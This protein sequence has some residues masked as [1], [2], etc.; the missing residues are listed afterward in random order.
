MTSFLVYTKS[1]FSNNIHQF[2]LGFMG[3]FCFPFF[4]PLRL[5]RSVVV[6]V[7][8]TTMSSP[9]MKST[10]RLLRRHSLEELTSVG[11]TYGESSQESHRLEVVRVL[12]WIIPV[13]GPSPLVSEGRGPHEKH[14]QRVHQPVPGQQENR[15]HTEKQMKDR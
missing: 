9:R 1:A 10:F 8:T 2:F 11:S 15:T 14:R 12:C 7:S 3:R 5:F 6:G 4:H 13:D